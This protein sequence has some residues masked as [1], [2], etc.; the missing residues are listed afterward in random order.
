MRARQRIGELNRDLDD[1]KAKDKWECKPSQPTP[2]VAEPVGSEELKDA[3]LAMIVEKF[4]S[5]IV[6]SSAFAILAF[7]MSLELVACSC[8]CAAVHWPTWCPGA[9]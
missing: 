9:A 6:S 2:K 4:E 8:T 7:T 3:I 5:G 1:A